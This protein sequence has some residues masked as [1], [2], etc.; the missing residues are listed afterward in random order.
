MSTD[1]KSM[2]QDAGA[3]VG[4]DPAPAAPGNAATSGATTTTT[5]SPCPNPDIA[6]PGTAAVAS[7]AAT[8]ALASS[9][10][11]QSPPSK[12][13]SPSQSPSVPAELT[14]STTPTTTTA[15]TL[16]S[17]TAGPA[18]ASSIDSKPAVLTSLSPSKLPATLAA[19]PAP[20]PASASP[21][22]QNGRSEASEADSDMNSYRPVLTAHNGLPVSYSTTTAAVSTSSHLAAASPPV[23]SGYA[24]PTGIST[25]QYPSYPTSTTVS[26]PSESY[27][28]SP[29]PSGNT[30]SL[31]SMRT[32]DSLPQQRPGQ[33]QMP[34]HAMSI[35]MNPSL[36]STSSGPTIY[37]PH[38]TMSVP[39]NY[40]LPSDSVP[41]YPLPHDPRILGSRGPKK[42]D[43]T[44]P[45][46]NNCKKSKRECL[47]YDPIFRQQ[48][49]AQ[50]NSHIQPAPTS[51]PVASSS[52]S[53]SVP[54]HSSAGIGHLPATTNPYGSQPSMLASSYST[55]SPPSTL[56]SS[57]VAHTVSSNYNSPASASGTPTIKQEPGFD[58]ATPID[59]AS[60]HLPP[61][62]GPDIKPYD[63]KTLT[64][65][66]SSH[67]ATPKKMKI[68]EIIDSLGPPPP[69]QQISHT[70]ETFNEITKVYHE[71]YAGGLSAFL[72]TTWYYFVDNGKM[73]FPRDA[74]L[75]EHMATF[76]KILEAVR[77]NDHSQMAYSGVL[78]TRIVWELACTAYRIPDATNQANRANMPPEGD[79]TE[80][81]NRLRVVEALLCGEYLV[82]NPLAPPLQDPDTQRTR[83]F[84]FWYSLAEFVRKQDLPGSHQALKARE[85]ALSRM[86]HLLDGRENRDVLYSI[87]VVRELAPY[88]GPS[89]GNTPQY[90]DET[91]P[92]NRLA[93]ASKF[94]LD[95]AQVTGG[96]TNVVRRFSDIAS[97]AFVNPGVNVARR[98]G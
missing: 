47:G 48:P 53:P 3:G 57:S 27:R 52:V 75:I 10:A 45:T 92:K 78:E 40:G 22:Q 30:L 26:H 96:T 21:S 98:T 49:G 94:I 88:Y 65:V 34:H 38:H 41:R 87:A 64:A 70:E 11:V 16:P 86:R 58:F 12:P 46:C 62:T 95:E 14:I 17:P 19:A 82:T 67:H 66:D 39:S 44:H 36:T 71:M 69:P 73:S 55:T 89:Y 9:S 29:V 56:S 42:C 50:P 97:R 37:P 2:A 72:E 31:P 59:P 32:I 25:V 84:D 85:D 20:A 4:S 7:V 76:L 79:A 81:R 83:Q 63:Y 6:T 74:N 60:R 61:P 23:T 18:P 1:D 15:A 51:Q 90:A 80:A 24:S 5:S 68:N 33:P 35:S 28:V 13:I 8:A 93:V 43:E 77:A 91:D 54:A